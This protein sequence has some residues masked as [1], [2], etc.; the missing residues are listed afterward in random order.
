[1]VGES[2]PRDVADNVVTAVDA[3]A[4][5]L[6]RRTAE[7]PDTRKRLAGLL[8]QEAGD[9][10]NGMAATILVNACLFHNIAAA[11]ASVP[12]LPEL[13]VGGQYTQN[14]VLD[15]WDGILRRNY[16]PIFQI[17]RQILASM[18]TDLAREVIG[19]AADV[20]EVLSG[21][22]MVTVGDLTGQVFGKL[23]VDREYLAA[24]YTLPESAALLAG[25][26]VGRLRVAWGDPEAVRSLRVGD[27]ACGTGALLSAVYGQVRARMRRAGLDDKD[28]HQA[29]IEKSLVGADV[30]P[31]AAHLTLTLLAAAHPTVTFEDTRIAKVGLGEHPVSRE[32]LLGS[33]DL[34]GSDST[35]SF[36]GAGRTEIGGQTE[37]DDTEGE[38]EPFAVGKDE[39]DLAIMNPPFVRNTKNEGGAAGVF[40]A[41]FAAFGIP[42]SVRERMAVKL[43]QLRKQEGS[44]GNG[45]VGLG[46]DFVGLA[47]EKTRPGGTVA[48]VLPNTFLA[49]RPWKKAR[50]LLLRSCAD[51][52]IVSHTQGKR[53]F[54]ADTG[55]AEVLVVARKPLEGESID[56]DLITCVTLDRRPGSLTEAAEVARAIGRARGRYGS[57]RIGGDKIG[58]YIKSRRPSVATRPDTALAAIWLEAGQPTLPRGMVELDVPVCRL[59]DLGELGP[60]SSAVGYSI[61]KGVPKGVGA[62][63]GRY[64]GPFQIDHPSAAPTYPALWGN[65][66][67]AQ[68]GMFLPFDSEAIPRPGHETRAANKWRQAAGTLH[69]KTEFQLTSQ[70]LAACLT[71]RCI[72]GRAWPSFFPQHSVWDKP[73]CLWVNTTFG[74]LG[75]WWVGSHQQSGQ[76]KVAKER[77]RDLPVLDCR[78]LTGGQLDR[79]GSVFDDF[80][81][82]ALRPAYEAWRDPVRQALDQAVLEALGVEWSVVADGLETLRLQWCEEPTVHGH[83]KTG[84]PP[85]Q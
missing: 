62:R 83:K 54:S 36:W 70:P 24:N 71:D 15:A 26:A 13:R 31:A 68:T 41:A 16:L 47:Y 46:S 3:V 25:I 19:R 38:R 1:M 51:P 78:E 55:M 14:A 59:D 29:I 20:V 56:S 42:E 75:Y 77:L 49:S 33:L 80:K 72:G 57:L 37:T 30:L 17:A 39:L 10:A 64:A 63:T 74:L 84:R 52:M 43:N 6:N 11:S 27:M 9:Q 35:L 8:Y 22:S 67:K 81:H 79:L 76:S 44:V 48:L 58:S 73:L 61:K 65:D 2:V 12:K 40:L 5:L 60:E 32:A 4:S 69:F 82:R 45:Q 28:H 85:A 34:S 23:I 21:Q 50:R 66:G 53:S 18:E 7:D